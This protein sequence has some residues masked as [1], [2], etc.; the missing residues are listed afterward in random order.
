MSDRTAAPSFDYQADI[1][2]LSRDNHLRQEVM[3][4][5]TQGPVVVVDGKEVVLFSSNDYLGLSGHV[6]IRQALIAGVTA[7]GT[8]ASASRWISGTDSL[9][10]EAEAALAA[11]VDQETSILFSSGYA[12]NVGALSALLTPRTSSGDTAVFSDA[13]NHASIVDGIRLSKAA[14]RHIWRH[15]D[16]DHLEKLLSG[17]DASRKL[18]VSDSFFSMDGNVADLVSLRQLADR[19]GAGLY[20]DEAHAL[21]V[22]GP[23]GKGLCAQTGVAPDVVVGTLGKAC[24]LWGAF[25]AANSTT[26]QWIRQRARAYMFSTGTPPALSAAIPKAIKLVEHAAEARAH[27]LHLASVMRQALSAGHYDI[28]GDANSPIIPVMTRDEAATLALSRTLM[29]KGFWA[30]PIR[31]P[32]VKEGACRLRLTVNASHTERQ[33]K[34]FAKTYMDSI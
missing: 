21:G 23:K 10:P 18:I 29:A 30:H 15:G 13:L 24:G 28:R 31:P 19:F 33:I 4:S 22:F 26:A 1:E 8:S 20:I 11:F 27:L 2:A 12:A 5:S 3:R 9:H 25:V 34:A 7:F 16:I 17:S 32:T 14:Q 6:E